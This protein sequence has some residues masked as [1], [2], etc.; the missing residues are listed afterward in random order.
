MRASSVWV[1][2]LSRLDST[3]RRYRGRS[4]RRRYRVLER[5]SPRQL[6][7]ELA[8]IGI[9]VAPLQIGKAQRDKAKAASHRNIRQ[10]EEL[11]AAPGL[12]TEVFGHDLQRAIDLQLLTG[13]P[14]VRLQARR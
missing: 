1:A 14:V 11:A 9:V 8:E 10:V 12:R 7:R 13:N 5:R 4:G 3:M 6:V 2:A